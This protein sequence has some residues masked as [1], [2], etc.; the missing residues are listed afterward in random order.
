MTEKTGALVGMKTVC[1][2]EDLLIITSNGIII[3][4]SVDQ[5]S[6]SGRSTQGVKV[7]KVADEQSITSISLT[8][9]EEIDEEDRSE[10][11]EGAGDLSSVT[12]NLEVITS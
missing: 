11:V 5:I 4:T 3:R 6:T 10:M 7:M 1:G 9:K 12:S 8:E 2:D